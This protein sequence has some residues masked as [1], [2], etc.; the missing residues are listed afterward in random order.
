[1]YREVWRTGCE[2][3][4]PQPLC[5]ARSRS[6]SVVASQLP[7]LLLR[8]FQHMARGQNR[9][10]AHH[11]RLA[12]LRCCRQWLVH[13]L[14]AFQAAARRSRAMRAADRRRDH[15]QAMH[16]RLAVC[17]CAHGSPRRAARPAGGSSTMLAAPSGPQRQRG[18]TRGSRTTAPAVRS[19]LR[20]RGMATPLL[21]RSLGARVC[22][23]EAV[24]VDSNTSVE[25]V[26]NGAGRVRASRHCSHQVVAVQ[27]GCST[28]GMS[29]GSGQCCYTRVRV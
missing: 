13:G 7:G 15:R 4:R 2:F 20:A 26:R 21:Q 17:R 27:D 6:F 19:C 1:M 5:A 12:S 9:V 18:C 3:V 10:A 16:V 23:A 11:H 24:A 8:W 22:V 25:T 29:G 28:R 14:R